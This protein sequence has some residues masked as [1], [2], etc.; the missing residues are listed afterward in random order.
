MISHAAQASLNH[1]GVVGHC[2]CLRH[3]SFTDRP[4]II[5]PQA[6][7]ALDVGACFKMTGPI[8]V[9]RPELKE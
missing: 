3:R 5:L 2:V 8:L 4:S 6:A 9:M 1:E 7:Q